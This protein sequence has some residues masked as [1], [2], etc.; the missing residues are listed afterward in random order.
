MKP[1]RKRNLAGG[2]EPL[3]F[4]T[5]R[6]L[7]RD[8]PGAVEGISYGTPA[9]RA[10][11]KLFVRKHQDGEYLVMRIDHNERAMRIK[12]DPETFF[13]TDHY[14]NY[15][16]VLVRLAS[17]DRDDLRDLLEESWR[18]VA[19]ARLRRAFDADEPEHAE[20]AKRRGSR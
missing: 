5:V 20:Q 12:A 4:E 11:G 1:Q 3:S 13:I 7:A 19:P 6:E 16:W 18:M 15:P 9:F 8:L 2:N 10:G 14:V 17:V